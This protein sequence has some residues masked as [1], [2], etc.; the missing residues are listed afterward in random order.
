[1]RHAY[2]EDQLVEQPTIGLFAKHGWTTVSAS[3][4][5]QSLPRTRDLLLPLL[6]SG[7]VD[8]KTN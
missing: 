3:E 4:E 6:L 8:L 1:M 2:V 7:Q 5:I